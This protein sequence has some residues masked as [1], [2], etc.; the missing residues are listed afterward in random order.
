MAVRQVQARGIAEQCVPFA[1]AARELEL[2]PREFELAVQLG[3]V[4]TV[5][6]GPGGRRRIAREEIERHKSAEGFPKELR[7]RLWVV[8]TAEGAE[9]MGISP[10]RFARLARGGCFAPVRFYVNR[11]RVVV[12]HYLASD[13]VEFADRNP[14][15]LTGRTPALLRAALEKHPDRRARSWRARRLDQLTAATGDPW[16]RAAVPAAVLDPGELA[17]AVPDPGERAYLHALR[18]VLARAR[19]E[20][21]AAREVI[22]E[23]VMAE[24]PDEIDWHRHCL[25]AALTEA[26]ADRPAPGCHTPTG[27]AAAPQEPTEPERRPA[28]PAEPVPGAEP[29][30]P[31]RPRGLWARL[32]GR[33]R[34]PGRDR[35]PEATAGRR[36]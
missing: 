18:P 11:Y 9:L 8:G 33:K 24:D 22:D 6:S 14:E 26:R 16:E 2:K 7:T 20:A 32:C 29:T 25:I 35:A 15:M 28:P 34:P 30:M 4:R 17:H 23:L 21:T 3:E 27:S 1:R 13:L 36:P 12:W 10:A 31:A 19:P 5:S